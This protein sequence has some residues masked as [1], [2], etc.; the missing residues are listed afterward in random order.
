MELLISNDCLGC[1]TVASPVQM[2][3]SCTDQRKKERKKERREEKRREEKR[4][5]EKR[6]RKRHNLA[7]LYRILGK[8]KQMKQIQDCVSVFRKTLN[9]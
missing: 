9:V 6:E 3:L 2:F 4:R 8:L 7:A 1:P 5:E